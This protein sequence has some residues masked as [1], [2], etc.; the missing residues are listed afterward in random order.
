MTHPRPIFLFFF[1]LALMLAL[2]ACST[3]T[4]TVTSQPVGPTIAA[5][6]L[7]PQPTATSLDGE[8][9]LAQRCVECHDLNRTE[10]AKKS[11]ASWEK[12]VQRMIDK[13]ASLTADEKNI[14]VEY[15]AKTY[16]Q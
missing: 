7:A 8:Q 10:S 14:L 1:L 3:A 13:G 4:P 5:P 6:T 12:T 9:L 16:P 2:A 11:A 15:L